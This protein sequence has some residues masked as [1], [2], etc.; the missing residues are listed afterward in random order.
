M[1]LN[2]STSSGHSVGN[3]F[4]QV[5]RYFM[6]TVVAR[7]VLQLDY[8]ALA[9]NGKAFATYKGPPIDARVWDFSR[10][11]NNELSGY[12]LG[13]AGYLHKSIGPVQHAI[14][15]KGL[16]L[17]HKPKVRQS[18]G[19][20][21]ELFGIAE[22][23]PQAI[24]RVSLSDALDEDQIPR[25]NIHCEYSKRDNATIKEMH[26]KLRDWAEAT[27]HVQIKNQSDTQLRSSATHVG[28]SCRMGDD[29][30][31]SVVDSFGKVHG[32]SNCYIADAS[33]LVTQGAGDSPSLTIQALALRTADKLA[34]ELALG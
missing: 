12:V 16:G 7:V 19:Q 30:Q 22:Q 5:G 26:N 18:F 25:V 32:S 6:E 2:T 33:V 14:A 8:D 13:V 4:D 1:L 17:A 9:N 34:D 31:T 3:Q 21:L 29:P 27:P 23:E 28:G 10:P 11:K 15:S 24:N 20:R